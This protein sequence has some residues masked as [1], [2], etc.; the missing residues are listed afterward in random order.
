MNVQEFMNKIAQDM[1]DNAEISNNPEAVLTA[2]VLT[3]LALAGDEYN[4]FDKILENQMKWLK[5][6]EE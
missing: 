6:I 5:E 4:M 3:A 2:Y 1:R